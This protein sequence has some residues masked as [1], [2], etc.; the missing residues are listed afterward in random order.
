MNNGTAQRSQPS[1]SYFQGVPVTKFLVGISGITF[2]ASHYLWSDRNPTPFKSAVVEPLTEYVLF[3]SVGELFIGGAMLVMPLLKK[4]EREFGTRLF[5]SYLLTSLFLGSVYLECIK[6]ILVSSPFDVGGEGTGPY[7]VIG[8]LLYL[9]YSQVPRIH[10]KFIGILGVDFSEKS[11]TYVLFA[12]M[13]PLGFL[14]VSCG[15]VASLI[16]S[17]SVILPLITKYLQFPEAVYSVANRLLGPLFV[18]K[19]STRFPRA[20]SAANANLHGRPGAGNRPN[21]VRTGAPQQQQP[22][23]QASPQPPPPS[24]DAIA[25]LTALGFDRE[26]VITTLGQCDNNVEV[27]ANRLLNG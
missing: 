1:T 12:M 27:A 10:P 16:C 4:F 11:M 21:G 17:S 20:M 24:E 23:F 5:F 18:D 15:F 3:S 22:A 6:I 25:N 9:Y 19:A 14:P 7:L 26:S 2:A 8:I 13:L